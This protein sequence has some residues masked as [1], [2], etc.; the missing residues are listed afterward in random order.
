M[1]TIVYVF[2]FL[3]IF[4]FCDLSFAQP[5]KECHSKN[6]KLVKM[7]EALG[8]QKCGMCHQGGMKKRPPEEVKKQVS[9][10]P[11]CTGCHGKNR[12]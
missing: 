2:I 10:D 7:H 9:E 6:P 4:S 1:R 8:F 11:L 3:F 12:L 5:C